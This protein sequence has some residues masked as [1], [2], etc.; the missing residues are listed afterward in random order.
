MKDSML[1]GFFAINVKPEHRQGFLDASIFEAQSVISEE[2]GVFQFHLM[3]DAT[4]PN[5]FYF[6]Q[7]FRDEAAIQEHWDTPVFM[8]W[9]NT[10]QNMIEGDIENIARMRSL[11]PT[12]K[13]FEAQKPG[14]LQW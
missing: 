8:S 7:V 1:G 4:N 3:V 12:Q 11:F 6:Y 2:P 14:L 13:G 5:R 10:I 9:W